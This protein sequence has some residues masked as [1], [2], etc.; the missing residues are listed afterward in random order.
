MLSRRPVKFH[1]PLPTHWVAVFTHA[2]CMSPQTKCA[3]V[4]WEI[5]IT[6]CP[7]AHRGQKSFLTGQSCWL[8]VF[9]NTHRNPQ[10]R[11]QIESI[12]FVLL[13]YDWNALGFAI[14]TDFLWPKLIMLNGRTDTICNAIQKP[15]QPFMHWVPVVQNKNI[16]ST[17]KKIP[18]KISACK[19]YPSLLDINKKQ[20]QAV[21]EIEF[22]PLEFIL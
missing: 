7:K 10:G 21:P 1:G 19:M 18:M 17:I 6:S 20:F 4:V 11:F 12:Q 8:Y 9:S 16:R 5:R 15:T 22:F 2:Q 3:I 14:T 13:V